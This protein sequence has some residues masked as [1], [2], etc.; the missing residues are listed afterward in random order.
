MLEP[1]PGAIDGSLVFLTEADGVISLTTVDVATRERVTTPMEPFPGLDHVSRLRVSPDMGRVL[2]NSV[3]GPHQEYTWLAPPDGTNPQLQ[4][5]MSGGCCGYLQLKGFEWGPES[6]QVLPVFSTLHVV[7]FGADNVPER[8]VASIEEGLL[9]PEG[10]PLL[11]FR[12]W[13]WG[14]DADHVVVAA[15]TEAPQHPVD[16]VEAHVYLVDLATGTI[17][18]RL[19]ERP[20]VGTGSISRGEA[21]RPSSAGERMGSA[22]TSSSMR[23]YGPPAF[24]PG[25]VPRAARAPNRGVGRGQPLVH[26]SGRSRS[27]SAGRRQEY[28]LGVLDSQDPDLQWREFG[29]LIPESETWIDSVFRP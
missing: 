9:T 19:T 3:P 14:H 27:A 23:A 13:S 18:R 17:E 4:P 5:D 22:S 12:G 20:L 10:E 21:S 24:S 1:P 15:N 25:W 28:T 29:D 2:Y 7:S 11:Q 8:T 16:P 26:D 6:R